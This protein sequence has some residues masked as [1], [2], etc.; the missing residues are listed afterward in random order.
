MK[1]VTCDLCGRKIEGSPL[2]VEFRDGE[3]PH[4]GST[5]HRKADVCEYCIGEIPDLSSNEEFDD[6]VKKTKDFIKS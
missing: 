3:H 4:C 5:M 2:C 6:M 1:I